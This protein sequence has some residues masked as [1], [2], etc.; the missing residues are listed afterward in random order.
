MCL[1]TPPFIAVALLGR[2]AALAWAVPAAVGLLVV[3][4]LS[5]AGV[6]TPDLMPEPYRLASNVLAAVLFGSLMVAMGM[7][8]E[9]LRTRSAEELADAERRKVAAEHEA[10][11]A[12]ADRLASL[13]QMA[14]GVAHEL[15]NPLTYLQSNL[16]LLEEHH[17]GQDAQASVKDALE[18]TGRIRVIVRDLKDYSRF[19]DQL[20]PVRLEAV[21]RTGVRLAR[22]E[23]KKVALRTAFEPC[24]LVEANEVRLGQVLVNLLVNATQAGAREVEVSTRTDPAGNAVL[25]VRDNGQG[26]PADL[27]RKVREPFFTTKPAGV[28]TGL[29]LSVCDKLVRELGGVLTIESTVGVGT[30]VTLVLPPAS[31]GALSAAS[32]G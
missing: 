6:P 1:G 18:A 5:L 9:W 15:N 8:Q 25:A 28:G 19:D 3:V 21:V 32:G 13:G 24:P 7:A 30:T 29:G 22:G 2:R 27:L 31:V 16:E 23:L 4:G 10:E 17:L 12:R 26:I 20:A 11:L 14:A